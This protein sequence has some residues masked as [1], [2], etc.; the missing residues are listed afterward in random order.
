MVGYGGSNQ[1]QVW[2]PVDNKVTVTAYADFINEAKKPKVTSVEPAKVIHDTIEVF[3]EPPAIPTESNGSEGVAVNDEDVGEDEDEHQTVTTD[4]H[5]HSLE[6]EMTESIHS[7]IE[8]APLGTEQP[9][10]EPRLP[11]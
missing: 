6:P 7:M 5:E 2:N 1:Y 8:V 10:R 9:Q 3:P 4:P 11:P